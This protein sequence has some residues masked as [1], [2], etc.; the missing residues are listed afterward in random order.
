MIYK[1]LKGTPYIWN[2]ESTLVFKNKKAIGRYIDNNV[3]FDDEVIKIC[4]NYN[5]TFSD[6][7]SPSPTTRDTSG[8]DDD[9][10]IY[11]NHPAFIDAKPNLS[12]DFIE[13][14]TDSFKDQ[15]NEKVNELIYKIIDLESALKNINI[16]YEN[17]LIE[18]ESLKKTF[19]LDLNQRK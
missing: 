2:P 7:S 8:S 9:K 13:T 12:L 16:D 18:N 4:K 19:K 14:L 17:L 3:V 5:V 15:L 1:K 11:E 6:T 10:D